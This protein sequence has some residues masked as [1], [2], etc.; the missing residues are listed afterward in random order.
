M[1][2]IACL[3]PGQGSQSVGMGKDLYEKSEVAR[4]TFHGIDGLAGR[5]LSKLSFEGPEEELKRTINTQPTILAVSLA[6]WECYKAAG[7]PSPTYVAGHSLGEFSAMAAAGVLSLEA[8]IKLVDKRSRLMEECPK[9]AM[10]A[11]IG[12]SSSDLQTHCQ[13]AS[14]ELKAKG[15]ESVVIIANYN[16]R[17]QLVISGSPDAVVLAGAKAKAAGAKVI[18]LAVGGAFHSPLMLSAAK[19]FELELGKWQFADANFPIVQ[20]VDAKDSIKADELKA[21]VGQQ[22]SSAVAWCDSIEYMLAQ[23]VDTFIEIG[24]GRALS[25]MVKK[26][27]RSAKIFNISD[28]QSLEETLAALKETSLA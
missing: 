1:K 8:T 14:N 25:G 22:M 20:N 11:V 7:G 16:T 2:K 15:N 28:S 17:E 19:E 24:P 9:G 3:F 6:A 4:G 13:E 27:D 26:I 21:K 23:G 18:P 12:M 5:P 10:S